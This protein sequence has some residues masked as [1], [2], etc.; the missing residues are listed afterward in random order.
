MMFIFYLFCAFVVGYMTRRVV[1]S[2]EE[3]RLDR[4]REAYDASVECLASMMKAD[5]T[6]RMQSSL[7]E[8][9]S[10]TLLRQR[11]GLR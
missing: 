8:R 2:A 10:R 4:K 11:L 5:A 1:C 6:R 9:P 7:F 3:N